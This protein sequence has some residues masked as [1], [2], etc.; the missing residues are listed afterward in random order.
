VFG[1]VSTP[2][3]I[4]TGFKQGCVLAPSLFN[5]LADTLARQLLP[6]V[7]QHGVEVLY[8]IDG[9][10]RKSKKPDCA[11]LVWILTYADDITLVCSSQGGLQQSLQAV[12]A[13]FKKWGLLVSV[14]KTKILVVSKA[15]V[16]PPS[17]ILDGEQV[18]VVQK[19]TCLGSVF[20]SDNTLD[21]EISHRMCRAGA[22]FAALRK[23]VWHDRH[24]SLTTKMK[25]FDS[26]VV[27]ALLYGAESWVLTQAQN[28]KLEVF[29]N[30]CLRALCGVSMFDHVSVQS[31]LVRCR[32]RSVAVNLRELRLRWLGHVGR[33][34]DDRIPKCM[35]FGA[36]VGK[37]S[38]GRP[39]ATW[40][41]QLV[42]D[43]TEIG[44]QKWF[45][46]CQVRTEW[47]DVCKM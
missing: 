27:S 34:D 9:Q 20:T 22:T 2:F 25:I 12:F 3:T 26:L 14:P 19:F 43:L 28:H 42:L 41:D 32:C 29:Y 5:L 38:V 18:E 1:D 30:N 13:V 11:M 4:S 39:K 33:M 31:L 45:K 46:Q 15:V 17:V 7:H 35:L 47:R 40:D 24:I 8:K 16:E 36:T 10:L 37:R 44:I 6:I 23:T 21:A